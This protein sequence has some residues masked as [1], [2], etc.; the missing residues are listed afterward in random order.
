MKHNR[1]CQLADYTTADG[2]NPHL[3][4]DCYKPAKHSV[5]IKSIRYSNTPK[6]VYRFCDEH[7]YIMRDT[8]ERTKESS[9]TCDAVGDIQIILDK[10]QDPTFNP[11]RI[12][13]RENRL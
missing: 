9:T 3:R 2:L 5:V 10:G 13:F 1:T 12:K 8:T 11:F 6:L 4:L 7:F